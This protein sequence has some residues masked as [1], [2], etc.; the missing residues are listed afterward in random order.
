MPTSCRTVLCK[1]PSTFFGYYVS[2]E[3][4]KSTLSSLFS[5]GKFLEALIYS[6]KLAALSS[7]LC[8]HTTPPPSTSSSPQNALPESRFNIVRHF[9]HAGYVLSFAIS[10][11]KEVFEVRVPR[12]QIG[13]M[14]IGRERRRRRGGGQESSTGSATNTATMSSVPST[15]S[16][17][18]VSSRS[19]APPSVAPSIKSGSQTPT[20][21]TV[22]LPME[23]DEGEEPTSGEAAKEELRLEITHW[24]KDLKGHLRLLEEYF[25]DTHG[26]WNKTLPPNPAD[27]PPPPEEGE[28]EID[29]DGHKKDGEEEANTEGDKTPR[30]ATTALPTPTSEL[31]TPTLETPAPK[32]KL[33]I[34]P[35]MKRGKSDKS[36]SS[37]TIAPAP[38]SKSQLVAP[39]IER[40]ASP[41]RPILSPATSFASTTSNGTMSTAPTSSSFTTSTGS[42]TS[43]TN[44][45]YYYPFSDNPIDL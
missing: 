23:G 30:M 26:T 28:G 20:Q 19:T 36:D 42:P 37:A 16:N 32:E 35:F 6:P 33:Q 40:P 34:L 39:V 22:G 12:L 18:L 10:P 1:C 29:G 25:N 15:A 7:P 27:L 44:G 14:D 38:P 24:W 8:E 45:M 13:L 3:S 43:P 2:E 5:F 21:R 9:S 17:T 31:P 41:Q 11:V 4:N